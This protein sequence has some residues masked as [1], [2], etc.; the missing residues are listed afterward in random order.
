MA[1]YV[2]DMKEILSKKMG[3]VKEENSIEEEG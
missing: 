1:F 2:I 3:S